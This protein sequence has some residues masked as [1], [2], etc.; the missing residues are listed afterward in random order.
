MAFIDAREQVDEDT[1]STYLLLDELQQREAVMGRRS[2]LPPPGRLSASLM[3]GAICRLSFWDPRYS[4][5]ITIGEIAPLLMKAFI[6]ARGRPEEF[7]G[8][9]I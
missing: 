8:R 6:V 4:L 3:S 7:A 1:A 5:N 9:T 2:R